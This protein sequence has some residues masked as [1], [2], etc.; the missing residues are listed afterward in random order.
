MRIRVGT[1]VPLVAAVMAGPLAGQ[2]VDRLDSIYLV[3]QYDEERDPFPDLDSAVA[4]ATAQGK[5]IL[6]EVGGQ[7]CGWCRILDRFVEEQ[8]AVAER[9][10]ER[11]VVVKVNYSA[12]NRN[13]RFLSRYPA[14]PGYPHLYVL[15]RDGSFLHS[16]NTEELEQGRTYSEAAVLAFLEAWAR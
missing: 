3:R 1:V 14:I 9:L 15:E 8:P 10:A 12:A 6:L 5:R 2:D 16:Q 13:E 7:W 4:R 11:F